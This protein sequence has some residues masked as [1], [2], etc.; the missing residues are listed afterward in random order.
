MKS[1]KYILQKLNLPNDTVTIYGNYPTK[2]ALRNKNR[3]IFV[4]ATTSKNYNYWKK[5][6]ETISINLRIVTLEAKE[7][8][9]I[10]NHNTHQNII[11]FA[12]KLKKISLKQYL[13]DYQNEYQKILILDQL[14]DPNNIGSV[15]RTAFAFKFNA[16]CI[17]K[18]NSPSETSSIIKASAGEIEK[19]VLIELGNL[20]QEIQKLKKNGFVIYSL[21]NEEG[22]SIRDINKND[23]KMALIVGS[24]GKG[25][26]ELTKKNSDYILKIPI[27]ENCNSLNVSN[28]TAIALY[29]ISQ[30]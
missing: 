19:I 17:L 4:L 7:L 5:Y 12:K 23:K 29:E 1:S 21:S 27:N 6:L 25:V 11:I 30:K 10:T 26:R 28:A 16:V 22:L 14:T 3:K 13:F 8:D 18:K 2:S 15:I 24:E 9:L 20:V